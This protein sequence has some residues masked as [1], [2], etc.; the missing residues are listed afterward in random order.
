MN[1][2]IGNKLTMISVLMSHKST[3]V[4]RKFILECELLNQS[5]YRINMI[6]TSFSILLLCWNSLLKKEAVDCNSSSRTVSE[7]RWTNLSVMNW[8]WSSMVLSDLSNWVLR[9]TSWYVARVLSFYGIHVV[10]FGFS[11]TYDIIE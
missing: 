4:I 9:G 6:V 5:I 7:S 11:Q 1:Q 10:R 3:S 8:D 2:H